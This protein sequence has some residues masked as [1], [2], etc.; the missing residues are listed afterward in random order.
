MKFNVGDTAYSIEDEELGYIMKVNITSTDYKC[1]EFSN[2][3]IE[4]S[5]REDETDG[6]LYNTYKEASDYIKS[7]GVRPKLLVLQP[8]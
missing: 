2:D 1:I 7:L 5:T 6:I 8:E 4:S 3:A